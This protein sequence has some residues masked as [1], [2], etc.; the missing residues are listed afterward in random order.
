MSKKYR[1]QILLE[2]K[3]HRALSEIAE[4]EERSISDIVR[5]SV[6]IYLAARERETQRERALQALQDL[7]AIR[8]HL[9]EQQGIF[10]GDLVAQIR[11]ER[12]QDV[13]R[14][15]RNER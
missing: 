3:Q 12:E 6:Q 8:Q 4:H 10:D 2:P 5:E 13:E 7:T 11:Q 15:W 14:V 9:Q 1:A